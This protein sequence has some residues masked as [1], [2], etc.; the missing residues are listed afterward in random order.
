M[1]LDHVKNNMGPE[2]VCPALDYTVTTGEDGGVTDHATEVI[3]RS[4]SSVLFSNTFKTS[5][6]SVVGYVLDNVRYVSE[7]S[8][9]EALHAWGLHQCCHR[10]PSGGQAL[11]VRSVVSCFLPKIRFL[12]LTPMEFIHGPSLHGLLSDSEALALLCNIIQDGSIPMPDG[13]SRIR[14]FRM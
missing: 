11:T 1:C 14:S 8:V 5:S 9:L 12:T 13:F 7:N 2:D 10:E 4:S 3:R 6:Q